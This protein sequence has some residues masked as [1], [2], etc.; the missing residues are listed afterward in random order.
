MARKRDKDHP[1]RRRSA[2]YILLAVVLVPFLA[3]CF[4]RFGSKICKPFVLCWQMRNEVR[5]I[6]AE[7]AR[8]KQENKELAAKRDQLKT[9]AGAIA[10][11]R[12]LGLVRKGEKVV[13]EEAQP[14]KSTEHD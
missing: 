4:V 5:E 6:E 10:E 7:N 11:A 12:K 1:R 8:L 14:Q 2:F 3:F 9:K 13:V